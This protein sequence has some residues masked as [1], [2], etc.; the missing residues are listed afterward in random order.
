MLF[1]KMLPRKTTSKNSKENSE[2]KSQ[3][4]NNVSMAWKR[5]LESRKRELFGLEKRFNMMFKLMLALNTP[6]L[7]AVTG[8][9]LKI[10]LTP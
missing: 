4:S 2:R 3:D 10:V 1:L 5:E 8:I 9:L 7:V 6:I